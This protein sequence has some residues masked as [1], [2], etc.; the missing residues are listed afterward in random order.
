MRG[1]SLSRLLLGFAVVV[2]LAGAGL[3]TASAAVQD[4]ITTAISDSSPVAIPDSV[5]PRVR[6]ATDLGPIPAQTGL[7]GMSLRFTPSAAQQAA[8]DQLLVDL[9][10]PS[11]P[12]FHQWLTPAQ[13]AAQFGLSSPDIAKVTAWLTSQG[14]TVT[15]VAQGGTFVTFDGTVAQAQTAF[16]T[17]IHSLSVDGE[18]HFA[19]VTGVSV[20]SAFAG[21]V[22]A[23]TG[24]H[25]FRLKPRVH[26]SIVKPQFTSSVSG[27]HFLAPGDIYTIYDMKP[28]LTASINGA[29]IGTGSGKCLSAPTGTTCG[30]IAVA[31]QVD[32]SLTDVAAFRAASGLSA[33]A[34]T[35][36][37]VPAA[38]YGGC[39]PGTP[40]APKNCGGSSPPTE[41]DLFESSIDVE[42]SGAMAPSAT[43]LFVTSQ[44]EF[45]SMEYAIDANVA[46]IVTTSYGNCEAAWGASDMNTGNQIFKQA[47]AQG[48]TILTAVG[49][50]GA[51][52]CEARSSISAIEGLTVDF[53]ASSPYVTGMGGTG[54]N[55]GNAT[56]ATQYWSSPDNT[57]NAGTAVPAADVSALSYIPETVW[58]DASAGYFEGGGGGASAFFSKPAWQIEAGASG[59]TTLVPADASRDVPDLALNASDAHDSYLFCVNVASGGSCG[60]GFRVSLLNSGLAAAGGTSLDSQVFGGMLALVEQKINSRIGN[61][62]PTLYA[63]GNNTAYYNT[64]STS[65]FHDVTSGNNAMPCTAGSVGCTAATIGYSAG[66]GYDLATGW[67]SVDLNNLANAWTVITPPTGPT[68]LSATALVPSSSSVAAGASVTL[69]A[70]V[71]S[72]TLGFTTTPTGTVQF[73]VNNVAV[74]S[75]VTLVNGLATYAWTPICSSLGPQSIT[76]VYSGDTNYQGSKGPALPSG[77]AGT[78]TGTTI[79]SDGSIVTSPLIVTVTTGPC[80][81]FSVTA[82]ASAVSVASGGTI[83]PVTITVAPLNGFTGTVVFSASAT[84]TNIYLPQ[85]SLNPVSAT[86]SSTASATTTLTLFGIVASLRLPSAP[87]KVDSATML[88]GQSS[89]RTPRWTIAGSGVTLASLLLLLL[90]RR[91]RLGGLLLVA[92]SVVLVV[93]ATGCGGSSQS[94]PPAT[95]PYAGTYYVTVTGTYTSSNNQVITQRT[96]PPVTYQIQ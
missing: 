61:A 59:M 30:D 9:Q 78:A 71:T 81:N 64:T 36:Q 21:V 1:T 4:R 53:P 88:A 31:G 57:F 29:G 75:P 84:S 50:I 43:V 2:G 17:S 32:I 87:G 46:P 37:V 95:N 90:P 6:L 77:E 5:H 33:N 56:Y 85:L 27:N 82:P 60:S 62:N 26:T 67:G 28:L 73:L 19:N 34:P 40:T 12:R 39:D 58:N 35:V 49:D 54:F 22:G 45:L 89:G 24:L 13:Y 80:P 76:A 15:G 72:A 68:H 7:L 20:P 44:N 74:G 91:R 96:N 79:A 69:T 94:A 65:V 55:E 92:L 41:G 18:I 47:N 38:I 70:T 23:V 52:D 93:G 11:S 48:Q 10:D 8:L 14:F 66:T 16:S 86:L 51:T 3:P 63:L 83:P 42:W 25:D